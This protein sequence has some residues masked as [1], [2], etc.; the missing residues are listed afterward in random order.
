MQTAQEFLLWYL[1]KSRTEINFA[2]TEEHLLSLPKE[3]QDRLR[4]ALELRQAEV[5]LGI[6]I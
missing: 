3:E 2:E 4:K 5:R 1:D 6:E